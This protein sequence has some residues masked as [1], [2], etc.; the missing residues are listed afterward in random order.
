MNK[1]EPLQLELYAVRRI[2][3][4]EGTGVD[5]IW[6]DRQLAE[7]R[8]EAKNQEYSLGCDEERWVVQPFMLNKA[9][10]CIA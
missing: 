2:V 3:A 8:A 5:S 9:E 4:Y 10:E 1:R 7:E 6:S